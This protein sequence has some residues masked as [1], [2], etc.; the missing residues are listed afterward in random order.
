MPEETAVV[1]G[2]GGMG[3]A[4]ARRIGSGRTLVLADH[5]KK[6]CASPHRH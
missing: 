4:I 1:I 6:H 5:A 3:R 2:V